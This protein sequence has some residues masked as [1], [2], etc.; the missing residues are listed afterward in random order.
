MISE[1]V[2]LLGGVS[3]SQPA[4]TN[5]DLL[6][7]VLNLTVEV[8]LQLLLRLLLLLWLLLFH[9]M[10]AFSVTLCFIF[11]VKSIMVGNAG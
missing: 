8:Q 2:D 5:A 10:A 6:G 9:T 4:T 7:G 3:T 1:E 11:N